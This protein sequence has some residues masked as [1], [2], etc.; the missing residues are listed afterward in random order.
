MEEK[1]YTENEMSEMLYDQDKKHFTIINYILNKNSHPS[2]RGMD[3]EGLLRD[4]E[5][6]EN[7]LLEN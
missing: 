5:D 6:Y 7:Y 3:F 4:M 2:P 1:T